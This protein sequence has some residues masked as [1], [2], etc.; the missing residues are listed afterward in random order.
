MKFVDDFVSSKVVDDNYDHIEKVK[1]AYGMEILLE[2]LIKTVVIIGLALA[3]GGLKYTLVAILSFAILRFF[4]FGLHCQSGVMCLLLSVFLDVISP[5]LIK[6][7]YVGTIARSVLMI[8][9]IF[10]IFRYAPADTENHPLV[11][12][13]VRKHAKK[14][15][16]NRKHYLLSFSYICKS[17][18]GLSIY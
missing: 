15:S 3:L 14:P 17:Q 10:I 11:K 13:E 16:C 6:D 2:N 9:Y 1:I 12:K 18:C 5:I 8:T 4:T 7:I